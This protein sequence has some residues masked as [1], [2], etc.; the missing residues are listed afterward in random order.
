VDRKHG[1]G[2]ADQGGI[3]EF[4]MSIHS[5]GEPTM[6]LPPAFPDLNS[7]QTLESPKGLLQKTERAPGQIL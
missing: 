3:S 2:V 7:T 1:A 4:E 6:F 5:G